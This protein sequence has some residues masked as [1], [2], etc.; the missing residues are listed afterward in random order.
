MKAWA[1]IIY[2]YNSK[3]MSTLSVLY[4]I[5]ELNCHRR[6]NVFCVQQLTFSDSR[7]P[8]ILNIWES[9]YNSKVVWF[10]SLYDDIYCN[11]TVSWYFK[12]ICEPSGHTLFVLLC[13]AFMNTSTRKLKRKRIFHLLIVG[14]VTKYCLIKPT[15]RRGH[16][17]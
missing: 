6:K 1:D 14:K 11:R 16:A 13:K 7:K 9:K 12:H 2:V 3:D 17:Q 10:F 5:H 4:Y 15:V 8:L